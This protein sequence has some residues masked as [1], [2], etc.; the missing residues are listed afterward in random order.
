MEHT[1]RKPGATSGL[2][3]G[4]VR[5]EHEA[6]RWLRGLCGLA[7]VMTATACSSIHYPLNVP[8]T[9]AEPARHEVDG[10]AIRNLT[11]TDNSDSLLLIA[12]F[13]GGGYRAAAM[14][15]A[16][17]EVLGE[18]PIVWDGQRSTLL[19]ELDAISA[20]SGGSLAAAYF[21][22]DPGDFLLSFRGRVLDFNLQ[23][24]LLSRVLSP[25][26]LWR[27]TS[28]TY[29]RGDLLQEMLD[30]HIFAGLTYAGLP[31]RRPMVSVNATNLRFGER[32][33]F[34]QD[35]FDHLCSD[36][37]PFPVA[38]A[39]AASMAVPLLLSPIT[40]WNHQDHCPAPVAT[41]PVRGRAAS[42]RYIHLVD[43]G[44]ADNTGVHAVLENVAVN[45]GLLRAGQANGFRGVRKRVFFVVNAQVNADQPAD[46]SPDTPG[47]LR[48]LQSVVDV[49]IDRHSDTSMQLLQDA[50][51][52]WQ[53]EVRA[54]VSMAA[55]ADLGDFTVIEINM[56]RARDAVGR[57]EVKQI[58]TGLAI[59]PDQIES[60]RRFVR[61]ELA[62][63][64]DWQRLMRE[65][66]DGLPSATQASASLAAVDDAAPAAGS[67]PLGVGPSPPTGRS[68]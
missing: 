30:K 8:L 36:L 49:P 9:A 22:R 14:A 4:P 65:L 1:S 27:Q 68:R 42:S 63:N 2:R 55:R 62:L 31:R 56:A 64:P 52:Q 25:S 6:F 60:I 38:R 58:P 33:E 5:T 47:L 32:F 41:L 61:R 15:F 26:G 59:R 20:V 13:S 39:V 34:S 40:L 12:A 48:Q 35:Q 57:E 28:P 7:T 43:G 11:A 67:P 16:F 10:Y 3:G 50:V 29:G 24:A 17:M 54:N 46:Q 45:G 51:R 21:A 19:K 66:Q 37:N 18:T 44:L 53:D 23:A